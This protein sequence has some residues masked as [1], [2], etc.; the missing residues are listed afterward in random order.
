MQNR[1]AASRRNVPAT[2]FVLGRVATLAALLFAGAGRVGALPLPLPAGWAQEQPVPPKETITPD[3][4]ANR[5]LYDALIKNDFAAMRT[6]LDAGASPNTTATCYITNT[7]EEGT[8]TGYTKAVEPSLKR[9]IGWRE[10][11]QI[12]PVFRLFLERGLDVNAKS[13]DGTTPLFWAIALKDKDLV[14]AILE[15]GA[16]VNTPYPAALGGGN[17]LTPLSESFTWATEGEK[18]PLL[19]FLLDKGVDPNVYT[20]DGWTPLHIAAYCGDRQTLAA[21]L[22]HGANPNALLK[23]DTHHAKP[24]FPLGR[25]AIQLAA[26]GGYPD[27]VSLLVKVTANLSPVDAATGGQAD[28]L[29]RALDSHTVS[30][31]AVDETGTPLLTLAARSGDAATV[32]LLLDKGAKIEARTH[33]DGTTAVYEAVAAKQTEAVRVLLEHDADPNAVSNKEKKYSGALRTPLNKAIY[34]RSPALV[35]LLLNHGALVLR[36]DENGDALMQAVHDAIPQP[37]MKSGRSPEARRDTAAIREA[38]EKIFDLVLARSDVPR[39]GG[40]ALA[41]AASQDQWKMAQTLLEK[42][43]DVDARKDGRTVLMMTIDAIGRI[44]SMVS[45]DILKMLRKSKE[46]LAAYCSDVAARNKEEMAFLRALLRRH[47]DLDTHEEATYPGAQK[48]QTALEFAR[49]GNLPDVES[50]LKRAG[51]RE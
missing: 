6:A 40:P 28:A 23:Q 15:R 45:P 34:I 9:A 36:S 24:S 35:E 33:T 39:F 38:Q 7:D 10:A 19:N 29:R 49:S 30:P 25:S 47:P 50:L 4:P 48:G 31:D 21:L 46:E 37:L 26:R 14:R 12:I 51:A 44:R 5:A 20:P 1:R 18:M 13:S 32:T 43:A 8:I 2:F 22:A 17:V 3:T 27:I 41:M 16:D 11:K 42:N